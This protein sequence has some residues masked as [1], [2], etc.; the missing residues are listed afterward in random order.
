VKEVR[1]EMVGMTMVVADD[2]GPI[3]YPINGRRNHST[4]TNPAEKGGFVTQPA[5]S[6][7]EYRTMWVLD[8][9]L[10]VFS[11]MSQPHRIETA[12][13]SYTPDHSAK[14]TRQLIRELDKGTPFVLACL[15][16]PPA[17]AAREPLETLVL[18]IKRDLIGEEKKY[19]KKLKG[20]GVLYETNG[21]HFHRV[22]EDPGLT[23][24]DVYHL[25]AIAMDFP[26]LVPEEKALIAWK[27]LSKRGGVSTYA[28]IVHA[29]GGGPNGIEAAHCLHGRGHIWIDLTKNPVANMFTTRVAMPP[30]FGANRDLAARLLGARR[31]ADG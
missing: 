14:V 26:A 19:T 23:A 5:E 24:C 17:R 2:G 20:A 15:K 25:P 22:E 27:H 8:V 11:Y 29:L 16:A 13:W 28:D 1:I 7:S 12:D 10:S 31:P 3:R 4:H 6:G 30:L 18:E 21:I 9:S